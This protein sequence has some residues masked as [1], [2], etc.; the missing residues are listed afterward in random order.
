MV[1]K[2]FSNKKGG[3]SKAVNYLLNHREQEGTARVLQGD[4]D[5]TKQI[6]NNIKFK[7]KT[8]V[9]CL[10]FEEQNI[11]EKMKHQLIE[12]FERMLIPGLDKSRYNIL[13]V[14]HV[15]KGRLEL[16]F[17]IPKIEL[18]TQKSLN[19]YY[20]KADLPRV[21]KWQDLQNLKYNYSS[22]KDPSKART[23]QTNSKEVGLSKDYEQLDK[24]L[25]NLTLEGQIKNRDNL[26]ELLQSNNIEVTRK[27]KD[28]LSIKLPESK[29]AKKFKGGIYDE[30]FT[31][32][33]E[34]ENISERAE[35]R[36][37]Q[38]NNRD[39]QADEQR[40]TRE[41]ESYTREKEQ[42]LRKIYRVIE[43]T[44]GAKG[45]E[46]KQELNSNT[47]EQIN[48]HRGNDRGK[49]GEG[50]VPSNNINSNNNINTNSNDNIRD[51][52]LHDKQPIY[53]R[54]RANAILLHKNDKGEINDSTRTSI[55]ARTPTRA[56]PEFKAYIEYEKSATE[57]FGELTT[58]AKTI[59][60]QSLEDSQQLRE[61]YANNT[62]DLQQRVR[63]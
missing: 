50:K 10:S 38:Y 62:R 59:R 34:I 54:Q 1:V 24:L 51:S 4:P 32:T 28:Y 31:S 52:V 60:E 14:E 19:P 30:Q 42:K 2:F 25:H 6:I 58:T 48:K 9:G 40:L 46:P 55:N 21:E 18:E 39:T 33:R 3:S 17:V 37:K 12:D 8:T 35:Q 23:L 15:D 49:T 11:S 43:P 61:E 22:P 53:E 44:T 20:H 26:I 36:V 57:L 63:I 45:R 5:L 16:N 27:G 29:K 13:W 41:L 56:R 7:Q 47:Q